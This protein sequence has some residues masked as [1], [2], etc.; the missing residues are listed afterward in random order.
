MSGV[1]RWKVQ[2]EI[3]VEGQGSP[4]EAAFAAWQTMT[5][6]TSA[7]TVFDVQEYGRSIV[8]QVS[9]GTLSEGAQTMSFETFRRSFMSAHME[10]EV[11]LGDD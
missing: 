6:P 5:D 7:A 3:D 10:V 4:E 2:W 9:L 11:M 1:K 8:L